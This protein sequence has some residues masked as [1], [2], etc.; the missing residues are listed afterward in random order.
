[1]KSTKTDT[2]RREHPHVREYHDLIITERVKR[3]KYKELEETRLRQCQRLFAEVVKEDSE[4]I[5][6]RLAEERNKARY[7]HKGKRPLQ[8]QTMMEFVE[9]DRNFYLDR[10][11]NTY[12]YL[13][14]SF[15]QLESVHDF[16]PLVEEFALDL[17]VS[18]PSY[19]S[20]VETLDQV[21]GYLMS[22][23]TLRQMVLQATQS[24]KVAPEA[25]R[26]VLFIEVF[27]LYVKYQRQRT[28]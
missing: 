1:V 4:T 24:P 25:S 7:L 6:T 8:F 20:A 19:R 27:G 18:C 9:V 12:V 22:H 23:E 2:D 5:D 11:K 14:D 17:A 13:L 15:L 28:R 3:R 16:S 10:E 26:R 21:L